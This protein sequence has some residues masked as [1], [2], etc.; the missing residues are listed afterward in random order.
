MGAMK[1][2]SRT[3]RLLVWMA[4][5]TLG[6]VVIVLLFEEKFIYF[7]YRTLELTPAE[8]GLR[9]EDT[10]LVA[11]DGTRIHGWFVPLEGSSFTVLFCHGNGGNISHRLDR[12]LLMRSNLQTDVMLFDYR[13]YGRSEGS[14]YEEGT[15]Q[16]ARAAYEFLVEQRK[17]PAERI[18]VF[19]ESLGAAVAVQ[20]VLEVRVRALILESPFTS[21]ADMA[22]AVYPFLPVA[23]F[24]RTRYDS[25]E[26]IPDI[27][28]PLLVLHGTRDRTVPFEQ[29]R[30][31][32]EAAPEP[33]RFFAISGAGHNDTYLVG[34]DA[35]WNAWREFFDSLTS[36]PTP[37]GAEREEEIL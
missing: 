26:K 34:G 16:D 3:K 19:G 30:R 14:P 27:R 15:Y 11:R 6:L 29:G 31:L 23:G 5:V 1:A 7:P 24:L 10:S 33:K 22:R 4:L 32:F 20:L 2:S 36:D 18:V 9:F 12:I 25:L 8:L 35:F 28:I 21:I 37:D 17:I 13:G